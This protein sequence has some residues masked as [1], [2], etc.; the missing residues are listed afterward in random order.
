MIVAAPNLVAAH[1]N[2]KMMAH[3]NYYVN[4]FEG[5]LADAEVELLRPERKSE[6]LRPGHRYFKP[7]RQVSESINNTI[8]TEL[9]LERHGGRTSASVTSRV[10]QRILVLTVTIWRNDQLG[11]PT[12]RS[13]S[14][15]DH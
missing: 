12:Q 8:N 15:Y 4:A 14:V 11:Q 6:K 10:L 3:K 5:A 7:F 1:P 2:Q 9:E 13:L